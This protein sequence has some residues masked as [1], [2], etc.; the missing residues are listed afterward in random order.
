TN[1]VYQAYQANTYLFGGNAPYVEEMYENYLANPGSVPDTWRDY[2]DALQHVP[3]VDGSNAKDVPHQPVIDAFA[4]RAKAGGTKVVMASEDA[5]MGRKRTAAQQLIAAYRNVGSNWA[6][7]DPLKRTERPAIPELDPA[8]YGF[9]EADFEIVFDTSNTFFGKDKMPLRELL[10]ALR[11]TYCSTIG[12]EYMYVTD[13]TQKRWW[14]QKLESVRSKPNFNADQKKHI[15][16]R[17]TAAEGLERFL[18][19]KYVGQ[20]RF[21]LEGGESFIAAMDE[22]VQQ[23]GALGVQEIVIGMAHR[24]RLNVLVNT[25]GKMPADLFAE[26]DH[27]APEEL[28]SGDVKYHQGFSS[29]VT[30]PGGPVHLS[31]AFN[32]SHLE[33]VNPVVE[34]SV[35]ARMDR[36]ADP[37]GRQVLPVLVHGDAAFAGQG[38]N[39][40]TLALAQTRGYT[41]AGT[42]HIIINNQ[43]GFTTSDPRDMRSTLYC[44]DIVKGVEAP[45]MHVNGDDPEA[46]VMAMQWALEYRMEFRKDVVLDIIC[47][48]K[49]GHNEQDTPALTQPL[50]YKKIG[51]HPGTR[52]LYADKLSAQ[53]LG[54]TLGDDMFKAYRAAMDSGKHT[55]DPVLT[56]FKSKYAVDWSPFLGKKWTDAGD[57][58]IPM[59]EWKRLAEKIT[60]IPESVKPHPLVKK[61][62]DDRAAMGRGDIPVDWGMGEHMAFASLVASGYPVRLSGED[63][64]RGTFTH[65]H[66]VIHDQSREKWDVGTYVALQN[67]A[68]NQAPFVVIDSILSEEAVLGFEYGYASND[69]NTLVIWEAQFGDFA[70]GAQVVIDQFIASGEVK[71]GR[72]N[73]LTMM[74]PHGYEGQGPEHSSARVERF[75]QLAADTNM[76]LVQPT[77]AS[78]IFHVLRRQMVRNLRKPLVIFTPKSLLRHKD[79]ASPLAEFTKGCFQTIIPEHKVLKAD[80]VKRVVVCSGKVYY[81][82]AKKR[83]ES[84]HTDVAILRVEQLYPFPHKA[85]ANELKKYPNATEVVWTQDEPQNQG[86]W[87][88]VQHYIH[89]NMLEGQKLGYSGRA[90]SASPAVGYSHLHQEQQKALVDG[91]F[92]KLKGFV[93]TK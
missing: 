75:M 16:D 30:S 22:L 62:Y 27:T 76:Q 83:E 79:A 10:N 82:L 64:G 48:R 9:K 92:G 67:V 29:D 59:A 55:V 36:R 49:L 23:A 58:A 38:V 14:Q 86:A 51:Q 43:I 21:S 56:N 42:V 33:I 24:G 85:F 39:Q 57:T 1:T 73:G 90:A 45:V 53:G 87:F 84:G 25:L 52:K 4:Q 44:T 72:V 41:T 12:A 74:L 66:A 31:L 37:T 5:E 80:K 2:F 35:R 20:K 40:E 19:T 65:R 15:L 88:F 77:T 50:M 61:V 69:P 7:L 28:P 32:P 71:W 70:N 47:Y 91:A 34:G 54:A 26:F 3:A 18:H 13:Q 6:D 93:L 46:V 63:C 81:D 68:E 8:F 11:E 60:T 89:E 17:L 78:Q